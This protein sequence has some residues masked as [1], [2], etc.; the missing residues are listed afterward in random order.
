MNADTAKVCT[1]CRT[2]KSVDEFWSHSQRA[3][4]LQARCID[5]L[6]SAHKE[7]R[8][9]RRQRDPLSDTRR[10]RRSVLRKQYGISLEEY[11][12]LLSLQGGKCLLCRELPDDGYSLAVDHDHATG[13]IRGLLHNRCNIAIG[14]LRDSPELC[15]KAAIYLERF[16]SLG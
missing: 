4:R 8:E 15:R 6:S 14:M 13:K 5:C 12:E 3:G 10:Y 9:R 16:I 7:Q 11:D 1:K 2:P